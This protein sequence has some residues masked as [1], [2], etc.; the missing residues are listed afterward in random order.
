M[1]I[2]ETNELKARLARLEAQVA[3]LLVQNLAPNGHLPAVS[4][5]LSRPAMAGSAKTLSLKK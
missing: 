4:N 2:S 1:N 5:D 3:E